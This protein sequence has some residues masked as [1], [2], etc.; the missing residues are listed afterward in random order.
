MLFDPFVGPARAGHPSVLGVYIV[1]CLLMCP[2]QTM[3]VGV[4][5]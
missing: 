4:E 2:A 5:N 1:V 3:P